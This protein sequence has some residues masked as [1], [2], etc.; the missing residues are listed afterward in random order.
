MTPPR[1]SGRQRPSRYLR[2]ALREAQ[3][4]DVG[5]EADEARRGIEEVKVH[6]R[7]QRS[8]RGGRYSGSKLPPLTPKGSAKCHE[9]VAFRREEST[10][11]QAHADILSA[12]YYPLSHGDC[13]RP[14][15][16]RR[17][18][19]AVLRGAALSLKN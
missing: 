11:G 9:R 18:A 2:K 7:G 16:N 13:A 1:S 3:F 8:G 19:R 10:R 17:P 12:P 5:D 4:A 6:Q 15:Y 14:V